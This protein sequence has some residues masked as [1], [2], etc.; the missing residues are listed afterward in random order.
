MIETRQVKDVTSSDI[1]ILTEEE[2][3][4]IADGAHLRWDH[5]EHDLIPHRGA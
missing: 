4:A 1:R 3:K 2:L 5:L